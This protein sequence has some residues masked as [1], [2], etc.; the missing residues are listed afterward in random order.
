MPR[1]EQNIRYSELPDHDK[2]LARMN[3]IGTPYKEFRLLTEDELATLSPEHRK[4]MEELAKG[5]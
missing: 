5:L 2:F 4:M 3:D 1:S